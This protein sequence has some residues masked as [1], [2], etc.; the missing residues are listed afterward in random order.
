MK[1]GRPASISSAAMSTT[2]RIGDRVGIPLAGIHLR[3][4]PV[5]QGKAWKISVTGPAFSTGYNAGRR[6]RH[7]QPLPMHANGFSRLGEDGDDVS[8]APLFVAPA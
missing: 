1:I 7:P 8:I 2:H 4:L 5:L 6:L 3:G